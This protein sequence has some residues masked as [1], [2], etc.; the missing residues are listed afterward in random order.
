MRTTSE[1]P[2]R[3]LVVCKGNYCRSPLAALLIGALSDGAIVAKSAGLR[4]WHVGD[5]A[6]AFMVSAAAGLGYDLTEHT[7][8][9]LTPEL[10]DWATDLVAVDDETAHDLAERA[11]GHSVFV[12]GG[13]IADPY[14]ERLDVFVTTASQIEEAA[15]AYVATVAAEQPATPAG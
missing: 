3:V 2:R 9:D 8:A 1:Q 10:I 6:H 13:G 12:L 7:G 5:P 4:G 11:P 15:R 14:G